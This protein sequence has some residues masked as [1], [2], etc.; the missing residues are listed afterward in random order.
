MGK[1]VIGLLFHARAR[2]DG[3]ITEKFHVEQL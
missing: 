1:I 3:V 2:E